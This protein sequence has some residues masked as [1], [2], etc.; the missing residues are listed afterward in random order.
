MVSNLFIAAHDFGLFDHISSDQD[1][2]NPI[3]GLFLDL[4]HEFLVDTVSWLAILKLG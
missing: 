1:Y 4:T 2:L 3:I